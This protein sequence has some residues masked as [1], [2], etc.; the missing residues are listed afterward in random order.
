[1]PDKFPDL[2]ALERAT[3]RRRAALQ[4]QVD[5]AIL[6]GRLLSRRAEGK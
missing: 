2:S 1:M 4:N 6:A 3:V 5:A